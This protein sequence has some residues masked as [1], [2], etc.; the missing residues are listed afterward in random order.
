MKLVNINVI[1]LQI[2]KGCFQLFPEALR[3]HCSGLCRNVD[4]I[5][6]PFKCK[7]KLM[8]TVCI[9][10][11]T[12][13]IGNA[14]LIRPAQ[15]PHC[16]FITDTLYRKRTES[17]LIRDNFCFS[18]SYCLHIVFSLIRRIFTIRFVTSG[19]LLIHSAD[20]IRQN[21]VLRFHL[22]EQFLRAA[23]IVSSELFRQLR[24]HL[25]KPVKTKIQADT[26]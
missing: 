6:H 10:T 3:R 24:A 19:F 12:V 2:G 7:P 18:K 17:I 20:R 13:K 15:D 22:F 8:L 14:A 26:L 4:L 16:L 1:R 9:V 23:C 25:V 11:R 5:T 21:P